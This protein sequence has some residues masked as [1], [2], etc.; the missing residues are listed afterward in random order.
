MAAGRPTKGDRARI[1]LRVQRAV[2]QEMRVHFASVG[3]DISDSL[4]Q[5]VE[6]WWAQQVKAREGARSFIA[7]Q[8]A[9]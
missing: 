5:V 7:Q 8:V 4:A 1:G 2:L 6:G 3:G 9:P